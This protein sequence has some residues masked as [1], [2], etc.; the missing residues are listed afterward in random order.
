MSGRGGGA[1]RRSR[2]VRAA[3]R[4]AAVALTIGAVVGTERRGDRSPPAP[5]SAPT[6]PVTAPADHGAS[7]DPARG[8]P[9]VSAATRSRIGAGTRQLLLVEGP[10]WES[11][12]ATAALC[13]RPDA[14]ADWS[15]ADRWPA[16]NGA[17]GWSAARGYGDLTSPVGVFTLTDAGGLLPQPPGTRLPYDEDAAFVAS[18]RG[19]EGEPL[20]GSFD[21]VVAIDFNRNRGTSPLDPGRPEGPGPGGNIWLHVDH[22]GPSQ[23]CVGVPRE[24]MR[25]IL[26]A[27]DPAAQPVVVMGP[28]GF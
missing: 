15:C 24:A 23:G 8:L 3:A 26:Q 18:G 4:L 27:L 2:A 22:G 20:A 7:P 21:H 13:T 12:R 10:S 1:A 9:G 19:V 25:R 17:R 14:D 11:S 28:R 6:A 16:R 5:P